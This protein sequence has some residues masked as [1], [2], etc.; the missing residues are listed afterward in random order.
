MGLV[1]R[2]LRLDEK[3]DSLENPS[4][5]L[6]IAL[7]QMDDGTSILTDAGISVTPE[8]SLRMTAV[9]AAVGILS[10][11]VAGLPCPIYKRTDQGREKLRNDPRW[12]LLNLEPNPELTSFEM[13]E[14]I[15]SQ[16]ALWGNSYWYVFPRN[17]AGDV[18]LWPLSPSCTKPLRSPDGSKLVYITRL[19]NGRD[20]SLTADQVIHFKGFRTCGDVGLSRI[21][22]AR[23]ALG[24][25]IAAEEYGGRFFANDA[26]PGTVVTWPGVMDAEQQRE[27]KAAWDSA[28]KGLKKSHLLGILTAG[29]D[30]KTVGIPPG[31]AQFIETRKFGVREVAR[32][33]RVPPYML[34]DLE[35]GSVSYASVEQQAIDFVVHSLRPWLVRIESTLKKR[36]F[37]KE[38]DRDIYPQ[39]N[40]SALLRGDTKT[41]YEAYAIGIDKKFLLVNE[42]RELE[43]L[44]LL[45]EEPEQDEESLEDVLREKLG[46]NGNGNGHSERY[47]KALSELIR[48]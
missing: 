42:V 27:F 37:N 33:F 9:L 7:T 14:M 22:V 13:W 47:A 36:L 20:H 19:P 39:F 11:S 17:G 32:I 21:M 8:K 3:R 45:S 31:D 15:V 5:D 24:V 18:E 12:D 38:G 43:D 4:V 46:L 30:I 48:R 40:V 6:K 1:R 16:V 2:I 29:A 28:H 23:Q 41:R 34:A 10:D 35:A 44:P 26:R 25:A